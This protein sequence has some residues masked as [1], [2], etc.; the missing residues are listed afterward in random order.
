MSGV[1]SMGLPQG[2]FEPGGSTH[3]SRLTVVG[4]I[5]TACVPVKVAVA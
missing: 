2:K 3:S 4:T 5:E 1:V